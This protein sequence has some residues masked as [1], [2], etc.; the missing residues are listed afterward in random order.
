MLSAFPAAKL[1]QAVELTAAE[2]HQQTNEANLFSLIRT[3]ESLERA[4]VNGS[5]KAEDYEKHCSQLIAQF[6]V[7]ERALKD[8]TIEEFIDEHGID[9]PLAQERLLG[10]GVAATHLYNV[11]GESSRHSHAGGDSLLVF[12]LSQHFVTLMD[13][14]KLN[15]RAVDELHP[16]LKELQS[17]VSKIANAEQLD[18]MDKIMLWLKKLNSLR[19]H[20]VLTEEDAR[21][22]GLDLENAYTS[23]HKWLREKREI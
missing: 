11:G 18:G 17:T 10:T 1:S 7:A 2:K 3:V 23:F 12:E 20:D 14:L 9:C 13:S 8:M 5:V 19:A 15:M 4:F 21:Q 16:T 22:M 6:R